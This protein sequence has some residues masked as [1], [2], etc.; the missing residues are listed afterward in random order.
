VVIAGDG[1]GPAARQLAE[2]AGWPLLA[3]PSSGARAGP[4]A[5][6]P[7]R[8]LLQHPELG[9]AVE[10]IVMYGTPSLSRQVRHLLARAEVELIVVSD[11]ARW[12]DPTR[13]ASRV[14]AEAA[15]SRVGSGRQPDA[16][17]SRWIDAA[18][19]ATRAVDALLDAEPGLTGPLVARV[20]AA[21]VGQHGVLFAG[22]S[23]PIRD[24]DLAMHPISAG[25]DGPVR[26]PD[27]TVLANRG[28]S[29]IDGA[30][31][32]AVGVALASQRIERRPVAALLGDL[33]FLH[34][35]NGLV[36]GPHESRPDLTIVVVNDNGGGLFHLLEHGVAEQSPDFERVFGTPHGVDLAALCAATDTSYERVS[37]PG[38]LASAL[39]P[40]GGIRV[41]EAPID[42]RA[43]RDL[44][45]RLAA[46][47][48]DA[49]ARSFE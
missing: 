38:A 33:T 40:S 11:R 25:L 30:V 45:R 23:S 6:G 7:Y 31:S 24:L 16:W 34:D 29:G 49:V 36:L 32:T 13:R 22:S 44:H 9:G 41:V 4:Y 3:E 42:R 1:A 10:R 26:E 48:D 20:T 39:A 14:V 5:I 15:P 8:L 17:L 2:G 35:S 28:L 21:S 27:L 47:V 43:T 37:I 19:A 46:A 18:A 12:P